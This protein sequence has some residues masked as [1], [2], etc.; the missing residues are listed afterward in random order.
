VEFLGYIISED[1]IEMAKDKV[2]TVL[3]WEP[4]KSLKET[5]AFLGFANFYRRFIKDFSKIC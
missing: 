5:Q 2:Q 1:G 4:P 3:V